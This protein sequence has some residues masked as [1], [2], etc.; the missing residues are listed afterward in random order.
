MTMYE[1]EVICLAEFY[2]ERAVKKQ[3]EGIRN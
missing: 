3:R 1:K 2:W